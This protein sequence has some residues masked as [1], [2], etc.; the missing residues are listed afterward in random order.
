M[1]LV[2]EDT[3]ELLWDTEIHVL[4]LQQFGDNSD[5]SKT[6][7]SDGVPTARVEDA[8]TDDRSKILE[9][10]LAPSN[11]VH[12]GEGGNPFEECEKHLHRIPVALGK[13]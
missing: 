2:P 3:Q 13:Q 4:A 10:H 7:V 5:G 8:R 6:L 12:V 1:L 9:I 11:F